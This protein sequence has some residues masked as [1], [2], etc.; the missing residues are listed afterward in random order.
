LLTVIDRLSS[1]LTSSYLT[2]ALPYLYLLTSIAFYLHTYDSAQVKITIVQMVGTVLIG[3]WYLKLLCE[4]DGRWKRALP[5]VAPLLA[6]LASGLLSFSHAAYPGPSLDECLRRVFYIHFALIAIFEINTLERLKRVVQFLLIATAVATLYGIIQALDFKFFRGVPGVDP[7]I[8]RQAFGSRVFSTF[9]N[10]NFYGN[11]LVIL[12]P[13][14]LGLLLKRHSDR[15][16]A[17]LGFGLLTFIVSAGLWQF[18]VISRETSGAFQSPIYLAVLFGYGLFSLVRFGALGGLFFLISYCDII[19]ES[20]G[21]WIGYVSGFVSFLGLVL[22][23]FAQF[24]SEKI[25]RMIRVALVTSLLIATAGVFV[26]SR[27]RMASIRF[28]ICTWVSTF[29]MGLLHPVWG[30]G[31][32]SFR[33][34]YPAF[35]RPQI[36]HIEGK[37]NT[38]TDH[39]ENEYWEVFQDEGLVGFGIFLWVIFQ[40]STL[41]VRGL[42]RFSE[43]QESRDPQ[44][45]KRRLAGDPRAYYMLGFLAAFWGMLMHNL[46]DVSLRFV[47]S[48]IFLWL[49]AGLIGALALHDPLPE[50]DAQRDAREPE[51]PPPSAHPEAVRLGAFLLTGACF[52]IFAWK[53]LGQF[54]NAQGDF[55]SGPGVPGGEPLLWLISWGAFLLTVGGFFWIFY[56]V[57]RSLKQV[58]GFAL[59]LLMIPPLNVFWGYFMADVHHNRGIAY[60][61]QQQWDKAIENYET[62]VKLNPNYIM[63]FYFMGNV[64][65]DRWQAGDFERAMGQYGKVWAI[66]PN[67]VQSHHQAGLVYLK[68]AQQESDAFNQLQQQGRRPEAIASLQQAKKDYEQA[69]SY[70]DRYHM[71]DPVFDANYVRAGWVNLRLADI[72]RAEGNAGDI[73]RHY[74][75]AEALYTE[76]L[77]AYGCTKPEINVLGENWGQTPYL[78]YPPWFQRLQTVL[79]PPA[80]VS[81]IENLIQFY[82]N[83]LWRPPDNHWHVHYSADMFKNLGDVRLI[84]GNLAGARQTY[85]MALSLDPANVPVLKNLTVVYGRLGQQA[86]LMKTALRLRTLAPNDPEVQRMFHGSQAPA[87]RP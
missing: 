38:E 6:S 1:R 71:I 4:W 79:M 11:F 49:L 76:S 67:Y 10:P 54:D 57:G 69:L 31:I 47:S 83:H 84:R 18:D 5:L 52:L 27:Q 17:V 66:A 36:F 42:R 43:N 55:P 68:K 63:S 56:K 21:A 8:W 80:T 58:W 28:R 62:V 19:T 2:Y 20:K 33:V 85:R 35:R 7:F 46:M 23:C 26:Y 34:I 25:Q 86:E 64:Y 30:N 48:G 9:G 53:V 81:F 45:G 77:R 41:G 65:T 50:T 60:S 32:G 22:F 73:Q 15:P 72:A 44:T 39:A 59:L 40:F 75:A 70:F 12:T 13:I 78:Y 24:R 51:S 16:G 3:F 74:D 61:K 82:G 29:E 14:T 87:P 37:H